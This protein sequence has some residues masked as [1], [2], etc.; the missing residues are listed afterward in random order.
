MKRFLG[1]IVLIVFVAC[2]LISCGGTKTC[3]AYGKVIS[4]Q[5]ETNS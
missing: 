3:P 2:M 5:T 1:L 4:E